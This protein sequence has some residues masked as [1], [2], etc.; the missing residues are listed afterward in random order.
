MKKEII[1]VFILL[2][3]SFVQKNVDIED[4]NYAIIL[5][6]DLK[7][8]GQWQA[9]YS[10]ADLSKV[11]QT[12]GKGAESVSLS[13]DGSNMEAIQKKYT[14]FQDKVF[15]YGHL[16]VLL[17]GREMMKDP[18]QYEQLIKEL[19]K[20]NEYSRNMLVFCAEKDASSIV[21]L[22]EKT[23]GLL[24]DSLKRLEERQIPSKTVTLKTVLKGYLEGEQVKVPVLRVYRGNP[25]FIGYQELPMKR[26]E[27]LMP[28][29]ELK[30]A[31]KK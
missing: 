1:A 7:Q 19:K 23:T 8:S 26:Q 9:T 27:K 11:A 17:I 3:L 12:K 24:A 21:K 5:G 16:K 18:V 22:D 29:E 25:Q 31:Q 20:E 6:M 2:A 15:E 13:I 30:T 4:R 28:I 14:T 10:F